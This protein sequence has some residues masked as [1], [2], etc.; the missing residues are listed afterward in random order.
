MTEDI[1][2]DDDD[3]LQVLRLLLLLESCF[4]TVFQYDESGL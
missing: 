3:D 4:T 1:N 2:D